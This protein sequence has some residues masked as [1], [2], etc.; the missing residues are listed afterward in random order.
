M[1]LFNYVWDRILVEEGTRFQVCIIVIIVFSDVVPYNLVDQ[2]YRENCCL[3]LQD[4]RLSHT[5]KI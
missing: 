1:V 3:L 2:H 5:G 4:G